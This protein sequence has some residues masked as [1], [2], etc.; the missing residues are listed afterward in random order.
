MATVYGAS[1]A[2]AVSVPPVGSFEPE[3]E[4]IKQTA[5]RSDGYTGHHEGDRSVAHQQ[6]PG[7]ILVNGCGAHC[8]NIPPLMVTG[9]APPTLFEQVPLVVGTALPLASRHI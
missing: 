7:T 6:K 8:F 5:D 4:P 9:G 2:G 1:E 3:R